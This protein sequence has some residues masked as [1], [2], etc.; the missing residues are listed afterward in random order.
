MQYTR[1]LLDVHAVNNQ[2]HIQ[3]S[4]IKRWE[5]QAA[6]ARKDERIE[7]QHCRVCHYL[8]GIG[9]QAMTHCNCKICD[10]DMCFGSTNVDDL[11]IDCAKKHRLCKHCG[12]DME[13]KRRKTLAGGAEPGPLLVD[14]YEK[15]REAILKLQQQAEELATRLPQGAVHVEDIGQ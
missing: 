11:C 15:A 12:C 14:T 2:T 9:G 7:A 4:V 1:K 13:L 8:G 3:A 10:K 6:D 5:E